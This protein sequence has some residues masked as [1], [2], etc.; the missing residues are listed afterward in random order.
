[1]VM[2]RVEGHIVGA[3]AH[4]DPW[5]GG[6]GH[7]DRGRVYDGLLGALATIHRAD[8]TAAS[9]V[10]RRDNGAELDFW[11]EYL[12]WSS[13]GAPRTGPG[14]RPGGA[15]APSRPRS[16]PRP[17]VGRRPVREHGLR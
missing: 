5:L 15:G 6:L 11:E 13:D 7:D 17:P 3:M 1:M 10:P 14:G 12:D 2:T 9:A 4:R 16:R 8:P